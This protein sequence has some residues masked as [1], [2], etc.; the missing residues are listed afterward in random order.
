MHDNKQREREREHGGCDFVES[1]AGVHVKIL[2][3]NKLFCIESPINLVN[4]V[5]FIS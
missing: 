1:L 3:N 5:M 2:L 4:N